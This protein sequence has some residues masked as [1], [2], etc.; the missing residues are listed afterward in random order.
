MYSFPAIRTEGS[1]P[2][3]VRC[4]AVRS[5]LFQVLSSMFILAIES[6]TE[7]RDDFGPSG[8]VIP[9]KKTNKHGKFFDRSLILGGC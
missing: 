4:D 2:L 5:R 8:L 1:G 6:N 3:K 7:P 9:E